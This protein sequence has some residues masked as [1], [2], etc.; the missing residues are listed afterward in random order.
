MRQAFA[1]NPVA[2]AY[3][4]RLLWPALGAVTDAKDLDVGSDTVDGDIGRGG[5]YQFTGSCNA[6]NPAGLRKR[7]EPRNLFDDARDN[8]FG[9]GRIVE[10]N[11]GA[12]I[13]EVPERASRPV[14][15]M[16]SGRIFGRPP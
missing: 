16:H 11:V 13:V 4:H 5:N 15:L 14:D 9:C 1:W 6:T 8:A 10:C 2:R 7:G 12:D 3:G